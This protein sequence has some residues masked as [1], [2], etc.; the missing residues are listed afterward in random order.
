MGYPTAPELSLTLIKG[1]NS[2]LMLATGV[3]TVQSQLQLDK[4]LN[5]AK[6]VCS[7]AH[8]ANDLP[9]AVSIPDDVDYFIAPAALRGELR[10]VVYDHNVDGIGIP[11]DAYVADDTGMRPRSAN[12][13]TMEKEFTLPRVNNVTNV[14]EVTIKASIPSSINP[15]PNLKWYAKGQ[16]QKTGGST[17]IH[18]AR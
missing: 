11:V 10:A 13:I 9:G 5:G 4:S 14:C 1:D 12:E 15:S 17:Y 16:L 7:V 8:A 6:V 18:S 2:R 3:T